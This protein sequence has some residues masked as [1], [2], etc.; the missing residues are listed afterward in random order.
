LL[1]IAQDLDRP[2]AATSTK[3]DE[4]CFLLD[5]DEL[6]DGVGSSEREEAVI[7]AILLT[8]PILLPVIGGLSFEANLNFVHAFLEFLANSNWVQV[9]GGL[10]RTAAL[11]PVLTGIVLPCVSFAL[12]T[13]TATTVSTLR[14]RQ[15][16]LRSELNQ[17]A[18]L[19]RSLLS[20][21]E[22]MFPAEHCAEERKRAALLLR[23]YCTRVLV[24]SRSGINLDELARQGAANSELDGVT[25]LLHNAKPLPEGVDAAAVMPRFSMHTEFLAQMYVEKLQLTRS[26]RL[27]VLQ[28]TFPFVHWF[29]LTLLGI[30]I[31]FGFLLAADQETLLF[32][33]PVQLRLLFSVLVGALT[34]TACICADLNDPFRGAFQI[35]PSSVQFDM[36]RSVVDQTLNCN[37]AAGIVYPP[38]PAR[39]TSPGSSLLN[40]GS[41]K[42]PVGD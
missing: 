27:A 6:D 31:V 8:A 20:A 2:S 30:S 34:A 7:N 22:A 36:I 17:E 19:V 40:F 16:Q 12:G 37:D 39:T 35:T 21:T 1:Q 23:Q 29:A 33:A 3:E 4:G 18:C 11:L 9:D 28:T 32:L 42:R 14:A 25:R 5:P 38:S 24:E 26:E 15:V 13:L 10:S 41:K